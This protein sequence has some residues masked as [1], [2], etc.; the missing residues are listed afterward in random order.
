VIEGAAGR[1]APDLQVLAA[2]VESLRH[3][4]LSRREAAARVA[5]ESGV[6]KRTL[7]ERSLRITND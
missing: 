1:D 5:E 6:S 3:E 2:R 4:G 7:Y